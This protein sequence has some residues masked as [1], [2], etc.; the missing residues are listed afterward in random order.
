M[1]LKILVKLFHLEHIIRLTL[2][3][4][5]D[6]GDILTQNITYEKRGLGWNNTEKPTRI[7]NHMRKLALE[8][9]NILA[10]LFHSEHIIHLG[11]HVVW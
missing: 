5:G 9:L 6:N 4:F 1:K 3:L 7:G 11:L 2:M 8:F 10:S